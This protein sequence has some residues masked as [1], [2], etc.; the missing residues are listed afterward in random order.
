[1]KRKDGVNSGMICVA[2]RQTNSGEATV[3]MLDVRHRPG[4]VHDS[5][6]AR[7]FI[8]SC[9]GEMRQYPAGS[10]PRSAHGL[11]RPASISTAAGSFRRSADLGAK[12]LEVGFI[13]RCRRRRG[14]AFEQQAPHALAVLI[15]ANQLPHVFA[16]RAVAAQRL[17]L[18]S[19]MR[20]YGPGK[21]LVIVD[22][23][24]SL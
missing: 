7:S 5:N 9:L 23:V 3:A 15:F 20:W 18:A 19:E 1:M 2:T 10:R 12:L 4:N 24:E 22:C 13:R 21:L 8:L 17:N 14:R 16:A 6:G 11:R